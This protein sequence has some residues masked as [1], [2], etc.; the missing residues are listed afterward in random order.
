MYTPDQCFLS[1]SPE[2]SNSRTHNC[3]IHFS[4]KCPTLVIN[5]PLPC[6]HCFQLHT[7]FVCRKKISTYRNINVP[8]GVGA[9]H[10]TA[11]R[12]WEQETKLMSV[13]GWSCKFLQY[14]C[15]C[16]CVQFGISSPVQTRNIRPVAR[17]F[18]RRVTWMSDVYVCMHKHARLGVSGGMLH[19]E[20]FRN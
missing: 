2:N 4:H 20:M 16:S 12:A 11:G 1:I 3:P 15:K 19:Q 6:L 5:T 8:S 7:Q 10:L 17:I 18:R 13:C 14:G 9:P